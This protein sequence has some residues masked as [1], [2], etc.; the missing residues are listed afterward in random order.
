M[1]SVSWN[2][3][4]SCGPRREKC[5][6]GANLQVPSQNLSHRRSIFEISEIE[7]VGNPT[8]KHLWRYVCSFIKWKDSQR[9]AYYIPF[10]KKKKYGKMM[11]WWTGNRKTAELFHTSDVLLQEDPDQGDKPG[12]HVGLT[13]TLTSPRNK[14]P[15]NVMHLE[16]IL[17]ITQTWL[18]TR[19]I[20]HGWSHLI[21]TK[22]EDGS[23]PEHPG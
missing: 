3:E 14:I 17:T 6:E 21:V 5:Q 9:T 2:K 13:S 11:T 16:W 19:E 20:V 1:W 12:K 22:T 7:R 15:I 10:Q 8:A 4:E 18:T 23:N